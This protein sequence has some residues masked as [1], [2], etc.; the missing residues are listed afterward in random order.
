[1][2]R[3]PGHFEARRIR[4][5]QAGDTLSG[6]FDLTVSLGRPGSGATRDYAL[7]V[8]ALSELPS[9]EEIP[10]TLRA[11][12]VVSELDWTRIREYLTHLVRSCPE[13]P[14]SEARQIFERY[15]RA[16]SVAATLGTPAATRARRGRVKVTGFD[17]PWLLANQPGDAWLSFGVSGPGDAVDTELSVSVV[18]PEAL[19]ARAS[20]GAFILCHR[21][22]IITPQ[23][24]LREV[25]ARISTIVTDECAA[26]D[27]ATALPLLQRYFRAPWEQALASERTRQLTDIDLPRHS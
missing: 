3:I 7:L 16:A 18:T 9:L 12:L 20:E 19:S 27:V 1:M 23:L 5:A 4:W 6:C 13:V 14:D 8:S 10:A 22:T 25:Q 17:P 11:H 2:V 24:D 21:A 26:P 15:F